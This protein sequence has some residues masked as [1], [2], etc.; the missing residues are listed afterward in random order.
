MITRSE[1]E[2]N[3]FLRMDIDRR[4]LEARDQNRQPRLMEESELPAWL[5]K[6]DKELEK[7]K[8]DAQESEVYGRGT[9]VCKDDD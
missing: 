7:M 2:Y 8:L 6:D 9:H 3:L 1:D 4:R 5:F